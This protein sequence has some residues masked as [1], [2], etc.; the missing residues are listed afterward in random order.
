MLPISRI[1]LIGQHTRVSI[2]HHGHLNTLLLSIHP[3]SK[4]LQFA[5][6]H[7]SVESLSHR[8]PKGC[9]SQIL[10]PRRLQALLKQ[11]LS[12]P[13]TLVSRMYAED[14][15]MKPL[16][17]EMT[18]MTL[19]CSFLCRKP[20]FVTC[21]VGVWTLCCCTRSSQ[22][23]EGL[24]HSR[25]RCNYLLTTSDTRLNTSF[26]CPPFAYS[27]NLHHFLISNAWHLSYNHMVFIGLAAKKTTVV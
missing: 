5:E 18:E 14:A 27:H 9:H 7:P 21:G 10:L 16:V 1:P 3:H 11:I 13:T 8:A 17:I 6:P 24:E 20:S 23:G 4:H 26:F 19:F 22:Q 2:I 12:D 15:E 25:R